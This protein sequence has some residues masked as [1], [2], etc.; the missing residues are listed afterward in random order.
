MKHQLKNLYLRYRYGAGCCDV[1]NLDYYL[2]KKI[3]RPLKE[4][5]RE[6]ENGGGVPTEFCEG[7]STEE[8]MKEWKKTVDEMIWAFEFLLDGEGFGDNFDTK[9]ENYER[10]QRGFE[11]FGKHFKSLWI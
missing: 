1:F 9:K 11:L 7:K 10:E 2:A 3:T 5:R 4:F 6:L 8:G